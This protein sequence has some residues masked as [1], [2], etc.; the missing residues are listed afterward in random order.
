MRELVRVALEQVGERVEDLPDGEVAVAGSDQRRLDGVDA[1]GAA[2][3]GL[4]TQH[5]RLGVLG[6]G[7]TDGL[8][9]HVGRGWP[10]GRRARPRGATARPQSRDRGRDRLLDRVRPVEQLAGRSRRGGG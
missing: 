3:P 2:Q 10:A 9:L 6:A 4:L 7:R 1:A 8:L 5:D